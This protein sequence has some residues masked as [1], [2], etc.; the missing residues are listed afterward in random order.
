ME[1]IN[2]YQEQYQAVSERDNPIVKAYRQKA[3]EKFN[4]LNFPTLKMEDWKYTSTVALQK[5][6]L[7]LAM[8]QQGVISQDQVN[9]HLL[10]PKA[11][12]KIV[13]VDGIINNEL[14]TLDQLPDGVAILEY[15]AM[16]PLEQEEHQKRLAPLHH[17]DGLTA[18]NGALVNQG[19]SLKID[20]Q[21]EVTDAILLVHLVTQPMSGHFAGQFIKVG[22]GAKLTLIEQFMSLTQ[23]P[24]L[25]STVQLYAIEDNASFNYIKLQQESEQGFHFSYTAIHQLQE[26][27][28]HGSYFALSGQWARNT[29][30]NQLMG[31]GAQATINGMYHITHKSLQDFHTLIHHQVPDC[32]SSELFKGV[33]DGAGRA[34]FNGRIL[35]DQDAQRTQSQQTNHN[36]ILSDQAEVDTKPQLEI[37]ADDVKCSHGTTIGQINE[38]QWFYLCARGI[39]KDAA[40]KMLVEG[41]VLEVAHQINDVDLRLT[42]ETLLRENMN[43]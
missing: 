40:K 33:L 12:Y 27:Y 39:D 7:S 10:L 35:V 23:E 30:T 9:T 22:K 26:S 19:F 3:W 18:L 34:V 31:V 15:S 11:K 8:G 6:P 38:E 14:S 4:A 21:C 24:Y 1:V 41:F 43:V 36:L 13:T 17:Q 32:T 29:I 2:H 42:V 20:D 16:S 28:F 25:N 5:L 37:F